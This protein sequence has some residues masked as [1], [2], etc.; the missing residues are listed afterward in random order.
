M[1]DVLQT[2]RSGLP[3]FLLSSALIVVIGILDAWT[4]TDLSVQILYLL[5]CGV[6]AWT[7][8]RSSAL[9]LS[10]LSAVVWLTADALDGHTYSHPVFGASNT[11]TLFAF[12]AAA[13][14]ALSAMRAALLRETKNARVDH[15]S[16]LWNAR[17]FYELAER[18]VAL[19]AREGADVAVAYLDLDDFKKVNDTL[20]HL[21]ADELLRI[22]A[23]SL[24]RAVRTTDIVARLGGDEFAILLPRTATPDAELLLRR[25]LAAVRGATR[26]AGFVVSFSVGC[27]SA[28][29][30]DVT[31]ESLV[32]AADRLMYDAKA[33]G[34]AAIVL[35]ELPPGWHETQ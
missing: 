17:A 12:L 23:S 10:G 14:S 30:E 15:L 1:D 11:I 32:R 34:K 2:A 6:V 3:M 28:R 24:R 4:G 16:G 9:M 20:G 7:V 25:A 29:G 13:C 8:G 5:P 31:F 27:V 21:K 18:E 35:T 26:D 22:V 33:A 19:G